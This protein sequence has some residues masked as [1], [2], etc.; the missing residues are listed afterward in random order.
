MRKIQFIILISGILLF[1]ATSCTVKRVGMSVAPVTTQINFTMDDLDFVGNIEGVSEQ[2]YV[3]G[4]PYGGRKYHSGIISRTSI[5]NNIGIQSRGVNNALYDALKSRPDADF[6]L[7]VSVDV[8]TVHGFLGKTVK[9][10]VKAKAFKIK[11]K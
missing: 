9:Y 10:K 5:L 6:L 7:P 2:A 8:E 4:L 1:A 11:T 3:I